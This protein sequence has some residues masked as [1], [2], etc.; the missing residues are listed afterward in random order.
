MKLQM[1]REET[2]K[3][4]QM[5]RDNWEFGIPLSYQSIFYEK[6]YDI[7]LENNVDP[8]S[9]THWIDIVLGKGEKW[10]NKEKID[11]KN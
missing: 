11:G 2:R 3:A 5:I 10:P 6:L 8:D 9:V 7:A 1:T 4:L